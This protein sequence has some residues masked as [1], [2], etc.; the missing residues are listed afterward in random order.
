MGDLNLFPNSDEY[1]TLSKHFKSSYLKVH[2][3]EPDSTFP[4]GL[5]GPYMDTDPGGTLDYIWL[6]GNIEPI[7]IKIIGD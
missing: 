1:Q 7:S 6:R 4:T 3:K 2:G 5:T